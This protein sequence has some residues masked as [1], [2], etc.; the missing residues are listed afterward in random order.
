MYMRITTVQ[1]G[2]A[3]VDEVLRL[4]QDSIVPAARQQAGFKQFTIV[5][6][7]A[8]ATIKAIAIWN[9]EADVTGSEASGYYQEQVG[10]VRPFLIVPPQREVY[11]VTY[12]V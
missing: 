4:I 12:Q 11:E 9:T 5:V 3:Q 1:V 10:K 8:S 6:D 7:R 2:P